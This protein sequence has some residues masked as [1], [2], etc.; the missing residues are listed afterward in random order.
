VFLRTA[1]VNEHVTLYVLASMMVLAVVLMAIVKVDRVVASV[2][3][4]VVPTVGYLYVSPFDTG[5]VRQVDVKVGQVVKKGQPLA[6]LDPTFTQADLL[7]L[8]QH[9]GSDEAQIA[10]EEAELSG[11]P[12]RFSAADPYQSIQGGIWQKRQ[13]QYLFDLANFD[14]QIH[15]AQAQMA[16][17]QSD[18]EKY[19]NRLKIAGDLENVYQPLLDKGYV[20]KLQLMQATDARTE[21]SRLL[22]DAKEQIPQYREMAAALKAQRDSYIQ[23]WHSDTATQ[24][25]ADRNDRDVTRDSLDKAQKLRELTT[26]DSPEDAIVLKVGKLSKGSVTGGASASAQNP[27]LDPLFTLSPVKA[28][29]EAELMIATQDVGFIDVGDPVTLKL[30]AYMFLR[31]GTAKGVVKSIS[32]GSFTLDQNQT[33]VPPYFKVR[34]AIKEVRLRNVPANFRLIPGNTLVGDVMVGRRTIL[35]YL[36]EGIMKTGSEGMREPE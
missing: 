19:E 36:V 8:Q 21:M 29:V 31:H 24:L 6:T 16:Q 3:G 25:V 33:P 32:E 14:G 27:D 2:G 22:A 1:P 4:V 28:P 20:S 18:A 13:A 15:A 26:L 12:Y 5:I 9:M 35:S 10:R 11:Q 7:Q 30:D 17:A 23:K 34:V